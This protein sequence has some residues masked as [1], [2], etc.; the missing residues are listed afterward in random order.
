MFISRKSLALCNKP[1]LL[2]TLFLLYIICSFQDKCSSNKIPRNFID[3]T[4]SSLLSFIN[5]LGSKSGRSPVLLVLW[6]RE[7]FVLSPFNE[8]LFALNHS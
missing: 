5:N 3:S 2:A 7:Y 4:L 8:S 6:N 1:I